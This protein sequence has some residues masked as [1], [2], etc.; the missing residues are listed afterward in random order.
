MRR[1]LTAAFVFAASLAVLPR[2]WCGID[3]S[4]WWTGDERAVLPLARAVADSG[5]TGTSA[6]NFKTGSDRFD[7]EWAYVTCTMTVLGL[8]QVILDQSQ[9]RDELLP[10]IHGCL[11][12]LGDPSSRR[13]GTGAWGED[14]ANAPDSKNAH[15]YLGYWNLALGLHRLLEPESDFSRQHDRLSEILSR[16][17]AEHAIW[18]LQTYPGEVYPPDIAAV[19]GS[20][21]LHSRAT[22]KPHPEIREALE[23]FRKYAIDADTGLVIQSL[24]SSAGNALDY[25]RGSGTA[26]SAYFLSFAD[27]ELSRDLHNAIRKHLSRSMLGFGAICEYP[28]T[29]TGGYGDID[30]GPVLFGIGVSATG[31]AISGARLHDDRNMYTRLFRTAYLFGAP[32]RIAGRQ[33]WLT[34]GQLGQAILLTMLTARGV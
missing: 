34:G 21:G 19:I 20:L 3:A 32:L 26:L 2:L 31:F 6:A 24:S 33:R 28:S 22:K 17:V 29:V 18:Q 25:P 12:Y 16:R 23:A 7:A 10:G 27:Q 11:T 30:S 5:S 9:Y 1:A 15:A 8:G 13:F 14:G 4:S